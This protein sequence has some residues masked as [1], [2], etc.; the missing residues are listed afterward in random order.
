VVEIEKVQWRSQFGGGGASASVM[1]G[2][3]W[4]AWWLLE[5]VDVQSRVKRIKGR[6]REENREKNQRK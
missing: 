5:M 4:T 1:V 2:G 6:D 3:Q